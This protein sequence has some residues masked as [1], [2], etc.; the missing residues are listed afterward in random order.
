[1]SSRPA[2]VYTWVSYQPGLQSETLSKKKERTPGLL[3]SSW[4]HQIS[5]LRNSCS[6]YLCYYQGTD[7]V[8]RAQQSRM[9]DLSRSQNRTGMYLNPAFQSLEWGK[10]AR[11]C[12][13]EMNA[14]YQC[15]SEPGFLPQQL[16]TH[17]RPCIIFWDLISNASPQP[18]LSFLL[19]LA[20]TLISSLFSRF[21][22]LSL[23][24][25]RA[26]TRTLRITESWQRIQLF[27]FLS[28]FFHLSSIICFLKNHVCIWLYLSVMLYWGSFPL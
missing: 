20:L 7:V 11:L 3:G 12:K 14:C 13:E 22:L 1:M 10:R 19:S 2:L 28:L 15:R 6:Q 27:F 25:L 18:P 9:T 8:L 5:V 17:M 4:R 26:S 24:S 23:L 21:F 16:D